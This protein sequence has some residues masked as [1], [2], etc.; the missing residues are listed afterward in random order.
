MP[1]A[2]MSCCCSN[3]F[4]PHLLQLLAVC[5]S[6]VLE[7]TRLVFERVHIGSLYSILHQRVGIESSLFIIVRQS[8]HTRLVEY[9]LGLD[10]LKEEKLFIL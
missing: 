5:V 4:H 9:C 7:Q 1:N 2:A 10:S 3:L 8:F 6:A